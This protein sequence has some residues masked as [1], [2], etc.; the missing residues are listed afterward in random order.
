LPTLDP[1]SRLRDIKVLSYDS[2]LHVDAVDLAMQ[3]ARK[4]CASSISTAT[5]SCARALKCC[6]A[7]A[8]TGILEE[9]LAS[10]HASVAL[11]GAPVKALVI[12]D[13]IEHAEKIYAEMLRQYEPRMSFMAHGD[14][15][16]ADAEIERFRTSPEQGV[17]VAIQKVTEGFDVP[18]ICVLTYLR[19]W[20]APLFI[21]Q[22]AGRAARVTER[23]RELQQSSRQ[24]SSFRTTQLSKPS[25]TSWSA[26]CACSK[27]PQSR[28]SVAVARSAPVH[29]GHVVVNV[30]SAARPG[31]LHMRL[32]ECGLTGQSCA[33]PPTVA[34]LCRLRQ[35]ERYCQC[36]GALRWM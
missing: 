5:A 14:A 21:N 29:R 28:A 3:P 27:V 4:R 16:N 26:R 30:R 25:L 36:L 24:P 11:G 33:F 20:K 13:G 10:R 32:P 34:D 35:A 2:D 12:A 15:N 8:L 19:T 7:S 22:M 6:A 23:E 17:L 31:H 9:R 1:Q 18:D